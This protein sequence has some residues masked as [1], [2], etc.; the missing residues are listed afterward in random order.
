MMRRLIPI[1]LILVVAGAGWYGW[2]QRQARAAAALEGTGTIE[3]DR[4]NIG[5]EVSGRVAKV[6]VDEGQTVQAGQVLFQLDDALLQSQRAQAQAAVQVARA[7]RDQLVARARPEQLAAAQATISSTQAVLSGAEAD[8][9]QLLSGSTNDQIAAAQAQLDAA[10]AQDKI[11]QD[12]YTAVS[13]G[14][15]TLKS[16]DRKGHGLG[17]VQDE[18]SVQLN[19]ANAQVTAAQAALN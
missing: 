11:T 5:S 13:N 3:A 19:A 6:L 16:L 17:K 10:Q 2:S 9:K 8:L 12:S 15:D 7:Q 4:V 1:L 18:L 14:R